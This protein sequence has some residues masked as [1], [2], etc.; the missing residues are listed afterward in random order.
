MLCHEVKHRDKVISPK[1]PVQKIPTD[2]FVGSVTEH[3]IQLLS[4]SGLLL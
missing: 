2:S 3:G 4:E 1:V